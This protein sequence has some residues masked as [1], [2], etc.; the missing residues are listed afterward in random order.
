MKNVLLF[1]VLFCG[2]CLAEDVAKEWL[3]FTNLSG[4]EVKL[5]TADGGSF[6]IE[7]GGFVYLPFDVGSGMVM[8]FLWLKD[9]D[10][11]WQ[12]YS[13]VD[14]YQPWDYLGS[15]LGIVEEGQFQ[16]GII[17]EDVSIKPTTMLLAGFALVAVGWWIMYGITVSFRAFS[18]VA[19]AG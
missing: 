16:S 1:L 4:Q 15:D 17:I 11:N 14:A 7:T 2:S 10:G 6:V 19:D 9:G 5:V 12:F 3:T 13:E 8:Y 18:A